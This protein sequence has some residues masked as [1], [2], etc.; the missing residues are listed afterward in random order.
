VLA[1]AVSHALCEH[2]DGQHASSGCPIGSVVDEQL[3]VLG[4]EALRVADMS[5]A[6]T[7]P[8]A[9]THLTAVMIGERAADLVLGLQMSAE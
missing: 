1:Q 3:S 9:N 4:V 2:Q 7:V 5:V 6:P 8:R